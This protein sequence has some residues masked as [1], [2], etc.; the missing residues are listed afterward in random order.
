MFAPI[1]AFP[2]LVEQGIPCYGLHT[3]SE[4][5]KT[6]STTETKGRENLFDRVG[7][8]CRMGAFCTDVILHERLT[9]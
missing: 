9:I 1:A 4:G 6:G 5:N 7:G 8:I 3:F 2:M